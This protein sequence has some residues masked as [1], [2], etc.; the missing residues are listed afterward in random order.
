MNK[1]AIFVFSIVLSCSPLVSADDDRKLGP[2]IEKAYASA[3]RVFVGTVMR[4]PDDSSQVIFHVTESL[5]GGKVEKVPLSCLSIEGGCESGLFDSGSQYLV[6]ATKSN[7]ANV[8]DIHQDVALTKLRLFA[9]LDLELL[10][11]MHH[12]FRDN[13]DSAWWFDE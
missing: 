5:K 4:L 3:D 2:A 1:F 13:D 11:D 12:P 8:Y 7:E 9:D 6:Y 10:R